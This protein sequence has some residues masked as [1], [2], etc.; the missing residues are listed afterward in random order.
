[1]T[2]LPHTL[3]P[4]KGL[5]PARSVVDVGPGIR[6]CAWYPGASTLYLEPFEGYCRVLREHGGLVRMIAAAD[7]FV[8]VSAD[9]VVLLDVIEH[10]TRAD[11]LNTLDHAFEAARRQVVVYTP[12]GFVEQTTDAWGLGGDHWQTHRSGWTPEDFP[13]W[14]IEVFKPEDAERPEGFYALW[15]KP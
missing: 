2:L 9:A 1:M 3:P 5:R 14:E 10:M 15:N 11:G 6:P 4:P 7:G 8:G 13:G 12:L